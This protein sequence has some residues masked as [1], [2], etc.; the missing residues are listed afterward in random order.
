MPI[1]YL[2]NKKKS[3]IQMYY[4]LTATQI[5]EHIETVNFSK[6]FKY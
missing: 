2:Q 5:Q 6:R 3:E 1:K 4:K